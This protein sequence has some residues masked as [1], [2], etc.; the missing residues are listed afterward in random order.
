MGAGLRRVNENGG[1]S[2]LPGSLGDWEA[3]LAALINGGLL[4]EM[5]DFS[6]ETDLFE[7]GLDSMS[8]MQLIILIEERYGLTL[9]AAGVTREHLGTV[10]SLAKLLQR[11]ATE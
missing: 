2:R 10:K 6:G 7:A 3:E 5:A 8:I 1:A 4:D 11:C 9:P